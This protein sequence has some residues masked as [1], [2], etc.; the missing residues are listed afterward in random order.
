MTTIEAVLQRITDRLERGLTM[1]KVGILLI[2]LG[3][4]NPL[5]SGGSTAENITFV[6]GPLFALEPDYHTYPEVVTEL[7]LIEKDHP[8]IAHVF[9]LGLSYEKR[10]ILCIKI[11]D[12]V[13]T[14]EKEPE[15]FICAM[16]HAREAAS[17]EVAMYILHCPHCQSRRESIR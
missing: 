9:S 11:S 17:V 4:I 13:L 6:N 12:N 2:L 14:D 7:S 15:V 3:S 5:A 10:D 1:K 8:T 16:H